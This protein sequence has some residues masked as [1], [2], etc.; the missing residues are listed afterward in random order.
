MAGVFL[1]ISVE[2]LLAQES[3]TQETNPPSLKWYQINTPNFK[4]LYPKGFEVQAQRMA[5][6]LEQIRTPEAASMGVKPKKI[7]IILQNQSSISN[8]FVTLAPRR[9]EFYT[10]PTQNYNFVGNNDWLTMLAS[11]EYRHIAQFQR[12]IT[13]FNRAVYGI[14]GQQAS[15]GMAFAAAPQWFWEGDAVATETAFTHSGRGRIPNFDLVFRTNLL[16]GRTFNYHKQ[17]LRSYKNNIP[18]HYVLG[19]HLVSYLRKKTGDP[20]IWEKIVKRSWSLPFIPFAFSNAIKKETGLYVKDLYNEMAGSLTTQWRREQ[21]GLPFTSFVPVTKRSTEVYTDYLYPQVLVDGSVAVQKSGIGDIE[22]LV[23]LRDGAERRKYVQGQMNATGM[24]SASNERVVWN[25]YRYDPRWLVRTYSIVKGY[26]FGSGMA[27]IVSTNSRYASAALSP[28]GSKVATI[29]SGTD[30]QTRLVILE[31]VSGNVLKEITNPNNDFISMPRWSDDGKFIVALKS[32][33]AGKTISRFDVEAGTSV[34]LL[35]ASDENMG[36]PVPF[37]QY[38]FYNSPYSGIDNIYA[39]DTNSGKRFQVTCSRYASYNPAITRDGTM[40]YYNE[41]TRNGMD[42]VKIPLDPA[43]WRSLEQVKKGTGFYQHLV[44]QEGRP[45]LLD[46][47]GVRSFATRR[48]HRAGG[49]IN[50]HSWGPYFTNGNLTQAQF[51]I[52]STDILST[53]SLHAGYLYDINERT[54]SWQAGVSYQGFYPIIDFQIL[55]GDRQQT[56]SVIDRNVK[57]N[58]KETGT[59]VGLRVPLV[60]TRSKYIT[61]IDLGNSLGITQVSSFQNVVSKDNILISTGNQRIVP[62]ND[63]LSYL[64]TG[65]VGNGQ[66]LSNFFSLSYSRILKQSRRDFNPKFAQ[67]ISYENYSTPYGGDFTGKLWVIRGVAYFPGLLKHHSLYF[68]GGY[69]NSLSSTDLNAYT[70]RNRVFKPRA[71]AYPADNTFYSYSA[72]YSLP[73]WYPDVAL[74]PVLN[75]QRVKLN[76]FYD[77]GHGEGKSYVYQ[78]GKPVAYF[79]RNSNYQST[80]LEMTFDVNIMRLLQQIELG[81]RT[82]YIQ[83]N[84]FNKSGL[85]FEFLIGAIPF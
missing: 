12:S 74:G 57:F 80:G 37:R 2:L 83:A 16:E 55:K 61:R 48:Y 70:F 9:S 71:Y 66:L 78:G 79:D 19:Y 73:V 26:D 33:K 11:H 45:N 46:S 50:P 67:A 15:A 10:M 62:L 42:V 60:L 18:N 4:V 36:Y 41:Q 1:L 35:P 49:M 6:T 77:V 13:G 68:R 29:E 81:F 54:G 22:Q 63:T 85:V 44:D 82:S 17:Y 38:I 27:T 31:Y 69:Q 3:I 75:I 52:Y 43:S 65:T 40:L 7:S 20:D 59:S 72:N 32:N 56:A 39:L 24:M 64:F 84:Q 51:G 28:D 34:D 58:W 30:Y 8:A 21:E 76:L 47:V 25:E 23:V 53:T 14:F 5:N